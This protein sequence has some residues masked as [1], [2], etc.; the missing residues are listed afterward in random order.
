[1][2]KTERNLGYGCGYLR[3]NYR[4]SLPLSVIEDVFIP[5]ISPFFL[6][7]EDSFFIFFSSI[8]SVKMFVDGEERE[9]L[10]FGGK[11]TSKKTRTEARGIQKRIKSSIGRIP[12][13]D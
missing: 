6:P 4:F 8:F 12:F 2:D 7:E 1:M 11:L 13:G 5:P 10:L 9:S 3:S